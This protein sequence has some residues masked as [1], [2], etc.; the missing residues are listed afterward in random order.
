M[1]YS[2]LAV[3]S[4][5]YIPVPLESKNQISSSGG[6]LIK[7]S[8]E[9]DTTPQSDCA[10]RVSIIGPSSAGSEIYCALKDVSFTNVPLPPVKVQNTEEAFV[11]F[12]FKFTV[13]P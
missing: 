3:F 4:E 11:A 8:K 6:R 1:E 9:S 5:L 12:P 7:I 10:V 13:A 2:P